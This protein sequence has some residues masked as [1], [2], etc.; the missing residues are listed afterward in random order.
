MVVLE[1]PIKV[2]PFLLHPGS[3]LLS[4]SLA[5]REIDFSLLQ[6]ISLTGL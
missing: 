5:K 2:I 3:W 6:L 1:V 4:S